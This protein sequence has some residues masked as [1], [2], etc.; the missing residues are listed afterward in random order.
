MIRV[1]PRIGRII[2]VLIVALCAVA[3]VT[4]GAGGERS[5]AYKLEKVIDDL[6]VPTGMPGRPEKGSVTQFFNPMIFVNKKV[7][8]VNSSG[9][10]GK[11]TDG[12]KT[13]MPLK[14][15]VSANP[16]FL[17]ENRGWGCHHYTEDGGATW[18]FWEPSQVRCFTHLFF[19]DSDFGWA[20]DY[21]PSIYHTTDGGR[22]WVRQPAGRT[23]S[24]TGLYFVNRSEGWV[25]SSDGEILHTSDG[26]KHWEVQQG[27]VGVG[28]FTIKFGDDKIGYAVGRT[29]Y[30]R[31][32]GEQAVI[33]YTTDGGRSWRK[34][35]GKLPLGDWNSGILDV[36]ILSPQESWAVGQRGA[37]LRTTD[38]G[39]HWEI[40]SL[41]KPS[42]AHNFMSA[43]LVEQDGRE[44]ILILASRGGLYRIWL[45]RSG[46]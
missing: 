22:T 31:G 46:R 43:A 8:W 20:L 44:A 25:V 6:R 38:G 18:T 17:N 23:S 16:F 24:L 4:S 40:I 2:I 41:D 11:T 21:P 12:G 36:V 27:K 33:F 1:R 28:L 39:K 32:Q 37:V 45:D 30:I 35:E 42:P 15:R 13:W 29:P 3:G 7:G 10:L 5:R 19:V 14:T 34:P 9:F 26:G